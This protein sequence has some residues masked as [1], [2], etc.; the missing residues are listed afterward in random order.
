[1]DLKMNVEKTLSNGST[2]WDAYYSNGIVP[3]I[4]GS[5][6][7]VQGATSAALIQKNTIPQLPSAGVP[8]TKYLTG[9]ISFGV[10][11]NYIRQSL[12]SCGKENYS[13][14][15]EF[16]NDHIDVKVKKEVTN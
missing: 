16:K 9:Q 2:V 11:D 12:K 14:D 5:N 6:E 15:Y 1:M 10:L 3:L 4:S 8:W 13:V 7:D